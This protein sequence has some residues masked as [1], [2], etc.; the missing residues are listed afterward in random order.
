MSRI[1]VDYDVIAAS[2]NDLGLDDSTG[3]TGPTDW[4]KVGRHSIPLIVAGFLLT[5]LTS[6]KSMSGSGLTSSAYEL[7][8]LAGMLM[9][10]VGVL[11]IL[12]AFARHDWQDEDTSIA[13]TDSGDYQDLAR[14]LLKRE[15]VKEIKS[16]I[17]VRCRYCGTLNDEGATHCEACGAA[18]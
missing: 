17:K 7:I 12:Y 14:E 4:R 8:G 9:I 6:G 16:T 2:T 3:I 15:V 13:D 1:P 11:I 18:L 10:V 5:V